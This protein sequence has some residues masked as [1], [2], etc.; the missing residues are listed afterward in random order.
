VQKQKTFQT[1]GLKTDCWHW[2]RAAR[3][4]GADTL[5]GL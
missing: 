5:C 3:S 1:G 2:T 4:P